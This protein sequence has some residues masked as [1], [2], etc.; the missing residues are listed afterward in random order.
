MT[1]PA[2]HTQETAGLVLALDCQAQ[3]GPPPSPPPRPLGLQE[4]ACQVRRHR[5]RHRRGEGGCE[6]WHLP[7][8]PEEL[9]PAPPAS[10]GLTRASSRAPSRQ[11]LWT[12]R[13]A[14]RFS[15]DKAG[16]LPR[17]HPWRRQRARTLR[18]ALPAPRSTQHRLSPAYLTGGGEGVSYN[19]QKA[20]AA[21]VHRQ[22]TVC[23]IHTT[24]RPSAFERKF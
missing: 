14:G 18:T 21:R 8:G 17:S 20:A 9:P 1:E 4:Q 19:S 5:E 22:G 7:S 24:E 2:S 16:L 6:L 3:G 10:A 11:E 15:R 13:W 12:S 23:Q